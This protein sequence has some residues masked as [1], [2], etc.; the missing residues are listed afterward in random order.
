[1]RAQLR[2]HVI[3]TKS[4]SR[5][6]LTRACDLNQVRFLISVNSDM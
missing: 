1:M 4:D 6:Q 5:S 2:E 3:L